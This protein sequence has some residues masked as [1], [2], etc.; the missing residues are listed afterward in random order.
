MNP[1]AAL[2]IVNDGVLY[3]PELLDLPLIFEPLTDCHG[4]TAGNPPRYRFG[5]GRS[6]IKPYAHCRGN[7]E[8]DGSPYC[9]LCNHRRKAL[10]CNQPSR[11]DPNICRW[12]PGKLDENYVSQMCHLLEQI[13]RNRIHV[14]VQLIHARRNHST[15]RTP[16]DLAIK[17][18]ARRRPNKMPRL[19]ILHQIPR[20]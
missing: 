1:P 13:S 8:E 3:I 18:R 20:L 12:Y 14:R 10:A 9:P 17:L 7:R 4:N 2:A 15:K 5:R 6:S 19:E 16:N 11:V